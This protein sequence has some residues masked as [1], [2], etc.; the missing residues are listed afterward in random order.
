MGHIREIVL[1]ICCCAPEADWKRCEWIIESTHLNILTSF[2]WND[3]RQGVH[4]DLIIACLVVS[5]QSMPAGSCCFEIAMGSM[6]YDMCV[7]IGTNILIVGFY[8]CN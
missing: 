6:H 3:E 4:W 7:Y 1:S 2:G 8:C 5:Q